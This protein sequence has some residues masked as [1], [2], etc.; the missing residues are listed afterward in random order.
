L[1]FTFLF[2]FV[3]DYHQRKV[4]HLETPLRN[5]RKRVLRRTPSDP[6]SRSVQSSEST[7][8]SPPRDSPLRKQP[9]LDNRSS[10]RQ[11]MAKNTNSPTDSTSSVK[12]NQV[13]PAVVVQ[14]DSE[15][16]S[17]SESEP[18]TANAPEP[19][20]TKSKKPINKA[21][22]L[23]RSRPS[24]STPKVT[25]RN[26]ARAQ[27]INSMCMTRKRMSLEMNLSGGQL[28]VSTPKRVT[29]AVALTMSMDGKRGGRR[30]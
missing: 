11:Q 3:F 25:T 30:K 2:S 9:C 8:P 4:L 27:R 1:I 24:S 12:E 18:E 22:S 10:R 14:S 15:I 21:L 16:E 17:S 5:G 7:A 26:E 13:P 20:P 6:N 19:R 23:I 29:R 28:Q